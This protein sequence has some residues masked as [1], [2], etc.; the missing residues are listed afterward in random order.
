LLIHGARS[1]SR[2]VERKTD[3]LSRWTTALLARR[4]PHVAV[5]A[6]AKKLAHT[7]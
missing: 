1:V 5:V 3:A 7:A 6:L 4:H 2:W